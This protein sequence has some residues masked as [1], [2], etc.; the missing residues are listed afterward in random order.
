MENKTYTIRHKEANAALVRV[1]T[2]LKAEKE[3]MPACKKI[4]KIVSI[5]PNTVK[6][7]LLGQGKDGY[8]KEEILNNL[9]NK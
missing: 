2:K 6:N 7:Y 5:H 4:A 9:K 3:L 1:S 8:L